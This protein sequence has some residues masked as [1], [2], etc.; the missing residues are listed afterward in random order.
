MVGRLSSPL[1]RP[2]G[3]A[4]QQRNFRHPQQPRRNIHEE[5]KVTIRALAKKVRCLD[6]LSKLHPS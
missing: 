5:A 3:R 2:R 6:M 4:R 1:P